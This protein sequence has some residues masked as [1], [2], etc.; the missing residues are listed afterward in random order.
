MLSE[1]FSYDLLSPSCL[2][3][4]VT[5]SRKSK[6][7]CFAGGSYLSKGYSRVRYNNEL[8]LAHRV[9]WEIH[10]G[11]IPEGFYID[12]LDGDRGNNRI[13][14][15]RLVTMSQNN[16]NTSKRSGTTSRYKGVCW[17]KSINKWRAEITCD[18][19]RYNLGCF[20]CEEEAARAYNKKAIELFGEYSKPNNF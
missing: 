1:I 20:L 14:N 3:W 2:T 10:F 5:T 7:G 18:N 16:K 15:L 17:A 13:E 4:K 12:H 6:E 9:V 11:K 8:Y 19:M